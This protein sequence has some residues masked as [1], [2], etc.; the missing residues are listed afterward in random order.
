MTNA[1]LTPPPGWD[2]WE[3]IMHRA[4]AQAHKA[5][6][7]GEVPVGAILLS[8]TGE[9]LAEACNAPLTMNDPSA[10]AEMLV[11]RRGAEKIGNYR[12]TDCVLACTLEPCMMC[13][14]AMIHARIGG[15]IFGARDLKSGALVSRMDGADLPFMNHRFPYIDGI[16]ADE[17]SAVLT[18]F[19]QNRRSK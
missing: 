15:L 6:Q 10:H 3:S 12:L 14:G 18:D 19:F 13:L 16:L 2:S 8:P 11:L 7:H 1:I 9:V 17:C 4:L 5:A